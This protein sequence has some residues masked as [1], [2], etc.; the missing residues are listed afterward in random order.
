MNSTPSLGSTHP[1]HWGRRKK[2][3]GGSREENGSQ[4]GLAK[5]SNKNRMGRGLS[6]PPIT[7]PPHA[8]VPGWLLQTNRVTLLTSLFSPATVSKPK[9]QWRAA[10]ETWRVAPAGHQETH[11][12]CRICWTTVAGLAFRAKTLQRTILLRYFHRGWASWATNTALCSAL[13]SALASAP[14]VWF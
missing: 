13:L 8:A 5:M 9:L 14:R 3:R 1:D 7:P 6:H 12:S 10:A 2:A 11:G 4:R